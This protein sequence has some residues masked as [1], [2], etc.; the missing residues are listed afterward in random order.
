MANEVKI[1]CYDKKAVAEFSQAT[2]PELKEKIRELPWLKWGK[3]EVG[4]K[5][6]WKLNIDLSETKEN[7]NTFIDLMIKHEIEVLIKENKESDWRKIEKAERYYIY[8]KPSYYKELT[9]LAE[10][11]H[12]SFQNLV[13]IALDGYLE[14]QA[15]PKAPIIVDSYAEKIRV[16]MTKRQTKPA[17]VADQLN[18][19]RS[20]FNSKLQANNF[21]LDEQKR[22]NRYFGW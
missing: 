3:K 16:E 5:S 1:M 19:P 7:L 21:T 22:I 12:I 15:K 18:I 17:W 9:K 6:Y 2:N 13:M 8:L 11:K 10:E 4:D 14:K 20:T